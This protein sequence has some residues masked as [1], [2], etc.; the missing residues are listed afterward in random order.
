LGALTG[1]NPTGRAKK[2]GKRHLLVDGKGTP[3]DA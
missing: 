2:G 1:P 3:L